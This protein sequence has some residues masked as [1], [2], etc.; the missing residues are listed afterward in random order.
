MQ[1]T[2]I[3][4]LT[5][6]IYRGVRPEALAIQF[7]FP[8]WRTVPSARR[9]GIPRT[10]SRCVMPVMVVFRIRLRE[11]CRISIPSPRPSMMRLPPTRLAACEYPSLS[12]NKA[13]RVRQRQ[14][15]PRSFRDRTLLDQPFI[16]TRRDASEVLQEDVGRLPARTGPL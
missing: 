4:P 10:G 8:M 14:C 16:P 7:S 1:R 3:R 11:S 13:E 15:R 6:P 5:Q 9:D 12:V 2:V